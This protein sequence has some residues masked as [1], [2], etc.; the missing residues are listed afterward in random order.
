ME[1]C[2]KQ[3]EWQLQMSEAWVCLGCLR[4]RKHARGGSVVSKGERSKR[5]GQ[6]SSWDQMV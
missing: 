3:R 1:K 5:G 6:R 2:L 4:T